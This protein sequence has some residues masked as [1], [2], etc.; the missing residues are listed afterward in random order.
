MRQI[1][2]LSTCLQ[3]RECNILIQKKVQIHIINSAIKLESCNYIFVKI[4][5]QNNI[6]SKQ[7]NTDSETYN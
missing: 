3:G 4:L 7:W 6:I 5:K 1:M 2:G